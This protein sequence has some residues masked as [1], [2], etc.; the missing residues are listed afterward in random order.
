[1]PKRKLK[2]ERRMGS[3]VSDIGVGADGGGTS[4]GSMPIALVLLVVSPNEWRTEEAK[5]LVILQAG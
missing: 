1:M 2:S 5:E 4:V 3:N